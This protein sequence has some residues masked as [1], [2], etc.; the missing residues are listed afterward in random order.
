MNRSRNHKVVATVLLG[1]RKGIL[2]IQRAICPRPTRKRGKSR[3][4]VFFLAV[5]SMS[6]ANI[7][8]PSGYAA[9]VAESPSNLPARC[10]GAG[11]YDRYFY[12]Q[13]GEAAHNGV[14]PGG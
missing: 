6:A 3:L 14:L 13:P 4:R 12:G 8:K 2:Q 5:I 9:L 7:T 10:E 1:F 11:Q